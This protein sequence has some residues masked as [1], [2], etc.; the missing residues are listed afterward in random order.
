MAILDIRQRTGWLFMAVM[1]GHI[2]LISAQ[3][4]TGAACRCSRRSPSASFAEVQRAAT[5]GDRVGARRVAELLRAAGDPPRERGAHAGGRAAAGR[6]AAGA[7]TGPAVADAA[8]AARPEDGDTA[9]RRP[10]AAVI[11]G[12]ASPEFRTMTIDKGTGDGLRRR[13]G[14]DRAGGRRRPRHSCRARGRR[15]C[16]CSSTANAAAA[17]SSSGRGPRAWSSGPATIGCGSTTCRE[18]PTSRS[19]TGS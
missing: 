8:G 10:P 18:R 17:R 5:S 16:S 11:A 9:R 2:I 3:V 6:P 4:S 19:G 15:R 1:V 12:G 13:H 14:G 7:G